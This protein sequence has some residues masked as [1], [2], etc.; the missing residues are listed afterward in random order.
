MCKA[1]VTAFLHR[2]AFPR[3]GTGIG[4][5]VCCVTTYG[6]LLLTTHVGPSSHE[7]TRRVG[8]LMTTQNSPSVS[9]ETGGVI[10]HQVTGPAHLLHGYR[11]ASSGMRNITGD[12]AEGTLPSTATC[13]MDK[14]QHKTMVRTE[15]EAVIFEEGLY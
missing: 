3:L 15:T 9:W 11:S 6:T 1:P 14:K 12:A 13:H 5:L 7:N 10:S 8:P 2:L 4:H